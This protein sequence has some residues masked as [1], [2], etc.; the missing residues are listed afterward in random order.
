M[1][2]I[3]ATAFGLACIYWESPQQSWGF[4]LLN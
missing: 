2:V 4:T 3:I 1:V